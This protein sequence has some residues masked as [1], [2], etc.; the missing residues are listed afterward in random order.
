MLLAALTSGMS[1]LEVG[2]ASAMTQLKWSRKKSVLILTLIITVFSL[3]SSF[4]NLSWDN[5][6]VI[7][8][9]LVA[10][11]G[12]VKG[13]FMDQLDYICSNWM[14]TLNGLASAVFAGWIWGA[15]K[16]ARELYRQ[17]PGEPMLALTQT[18]KI[19]RILLRQ[20]PIKS[21]AYFVLFIS[22]ILVLITFLFATGFFS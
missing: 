16:A 11:F 10:A 5:L 6:P 7:K 4:S 12:S 1:L 22:P 17:D 13:S 14:L 20:V 3:L 9:F 2:I 18:E 15:G 19:K 21:W 8:N